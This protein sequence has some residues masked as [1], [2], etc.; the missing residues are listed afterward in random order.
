[1]SKCW[2]QSANSKP[3][4]PAPAMSTGCCLVLSIVDNVGDCFKAVVIVEVDQKESVDR[5]ATPIYVSSA[6]L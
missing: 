2:N 6:R 3:V 5:G 1:M 4:G